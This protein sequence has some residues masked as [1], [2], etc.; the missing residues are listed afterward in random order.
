MHQLLS[1][2][3][4]SQFVEMS[5]V[6]R[7]MARDD[8]D[9]LALELMNAH[10]RIPAFVPSIAGQTLPAGLAVDAVVR[11]RAVVGARFNAKRQIVGI[12]LFIPTTREIV[13]ES[14][15]LADPFQLPLTAI[16]RTAR[17]SPARIVP[18]GWCASA[19]SRWS[20]ESTTCICATPKG[21]SRCTPRRSRP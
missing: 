2:G 20:R 11:L 4:D 10:E 6:V 1:G 17:I 15:A 5:G 19:G 18:A 7:S 14:P 13:V 8:K 21:A 3:E 12:Q 9:H 16:E